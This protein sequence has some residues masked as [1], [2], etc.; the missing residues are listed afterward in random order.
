MMLAVHFQHNAY[1]IHN[2]Q[3]A[4]CFVENAGKPN[5]IS[6]I[7]SKL[8]LVARYSTLMSCRESYLC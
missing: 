6:K 4:N 7:R 8:M 1:F 2:T 5:K 3:T